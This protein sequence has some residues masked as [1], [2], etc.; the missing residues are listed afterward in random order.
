MHGSVLGDSMFG[1]RIAHT[2]GFISNF[3]LPGKIELTHA[4]K[5]RIRQDLAHRPQQAGRNAPRE[6][7]LQDS[8]SLAA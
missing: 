4:R 5:M 2:A 6:T 8:I 7:T 1:K 3:H